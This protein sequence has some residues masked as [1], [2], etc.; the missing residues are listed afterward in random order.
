MVLGKPNRFEPKFFSVDDLLNRLTVAL[1]LLGAF[2]PLYRMEEAELH[3]LRSS[4]VLLTVTSPILTLEMRWRQ[5]RHVAEAPH[6]FPDRAAPRP[7]AAP[8]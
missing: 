3:S 8:R 6:H 2:W 7:R 4:Q 1:G 5:V